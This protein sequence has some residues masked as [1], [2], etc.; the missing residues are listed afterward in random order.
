MN[1]TLFMQINHCLITLAK[2]GSLHHR[3]LAFKFLQNK[4]AVSTLFDEIGPKYSDRAGGYTRIIKLGFRL[5]DAAPI[6]MLEFVDISKPENKPKKEK[7]ASKKTKEKEKEKEVT[8]AE[9][10]S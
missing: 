1:I 7:A 10:A 3:R 4:Q 9:A 2:K 8:E 6:S 5:G